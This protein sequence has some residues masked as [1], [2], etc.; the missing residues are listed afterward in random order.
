M[1]N[2]KLFGFVFAA[3][4]S[5]F[6]ASC[7]EAEVYPIMLGTGVTL[8]NTIEIAAVDSMGGTNGMEVPV[9]T[10]LNV[11]AN[12]LE[13]SSSISADAIEFS[14]F[15][16][17]WDIDVEEELIKFTNLVTANNEPYPGYL[18]VVE[19]GTFD[20]YYFKFE[21]TVTPPNM[22][23][24][25]SPHVTAQMLSDTEL[26]ITIGEGYDTASSGFEVSLED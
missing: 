14:N 21:S 9:E 12:S 25:S 1:K 15:I 19:A 11:S 10:F 23:E 22:M 8:N 5:V 16:A 18:R 6:F 3:A 17:R 13:G 2:F 24:I 7:E 4:V 20:R 26:V